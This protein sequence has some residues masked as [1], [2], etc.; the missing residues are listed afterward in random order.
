MFLEVAHILRNRWRERAEWQWY[1]PW[2]LAAES[3]GVEDTCP[4]RQESR[5]HSA[6]PDAAVPKLNENEDTYQCHPMPL[7]MFQR[8]RGRVF[9]ELLSLSLSRFSGRD[10]LMETT[11]YSSCLS[12][13]TMSKELAQFRSWWRM[14]PVRFC[15]AQ[16]RARIWILSSFLL[17]CSCVSYVLWQ[18]ACRWRWS[19]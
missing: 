1:F 15:V 5:R 3:M 16:G 14:P 18:P 9:I 11:S 12:M 19:W 13:A 7:S 8:H 2:L 6:P 4:Q 10:I 17:C